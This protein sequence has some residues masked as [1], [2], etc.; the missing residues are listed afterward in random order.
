[1]L[2]SLTRWPFESRTTTTTYTVALASVSLFYVLWKRRSSRRAKGVQV[3][4]P[5]KG[6]RDVSFLHMFLRGADGKIGYSPFAIKLETFLRINN[7]PYV[8]VFDSF[9]SP[10]HRV[11][12][13]AEYD[14]VIYEDIDEAISAISTKTN[15][16]MDSHLTLEQ[17][18]VGRSLQ[19]MLEHHL[20]WTILMDRWVYGKGCFVWVRPAKIAL[21]MSVSL[22]QKINSEHGR[23]SRI[24]AVQTR[25]PACHWDRAN[26]DGGPNLLAWHRKKVSRA[27]VKRRPHGR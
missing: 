10:Q 12:P 11:T 15:A 24:M 8:V 14:G 23:C 27:S 20:Y 3:R 4:R 21:N 1:M 16:D 5:H 9:V 13:W 2:A 19:A 25:R 6:Q 17:K 18:A 22:K 26:Q 7:L